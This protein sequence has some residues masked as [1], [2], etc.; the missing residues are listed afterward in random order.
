[1]SFEFY[2]VAKPPFE[3][4]F[5]LLKAS[6]DTFHPEGWMIDFSARTGVSK[7]ALHLFPGKL[8]APL[9]LE[10]GEF[11]LKYCFV[12]DFFLQ[13][14]PAFTE[15]LLVPKPDRWGNDFDQVVEA[16]EG[17]LLKHRWQVM[18][19]IR[20]LDD[21][22]VLKNRRYTIGTESFVIK[23]PSTLLDAGESFVVTRS[24]EIDI[25]AKKFFNKMPEKRCSGGGSDGGGDIF[26]FF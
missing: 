22:H 9:T 17:R 26:L 19:A 20:I 18:K 12:A 8:V 23:D 7:A 15:P 3:F 25:A 13:S 4:P 10:Y 2:L 6:I 21:Y 14:V 11:P 16:V 1:M 24:K 5:P